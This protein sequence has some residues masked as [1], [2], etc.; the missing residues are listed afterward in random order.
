M[1]YRDAWGLPRPGSALTGSALAEFRHNA[2]NSLAYLDLIEAVERG[3]LDGDSTTE[4][5]NELCDVYVVKLGSWASMEA[6]LLT[7]IVADA[8]SIRR[9][10]KVLRVPRSTLGSWLVRVRNS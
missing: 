8:G 2:P 10:S 3:A 6:Y 5:P 4:S 9:A 1:S 7:Q